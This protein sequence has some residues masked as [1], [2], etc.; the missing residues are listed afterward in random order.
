MEA[1]TAAARR[2][3]AGDLRPA[4]ARERRRTR[5]GTSRAPSTR[6]P[7]RSRAR[8]RCAAPWSP[9]WPTSCARRS[10]TCAARSRPSRTGCSRPDAATV[11]S[12]HEETLLLAR[13]VGDLQDLALAESGQLPLHSGAVSRSRTRCAPRWPRSG[14][15]PARGGS[16]SRRTFADGAWPWTPTASGWPR[17]CATCSRT[18]SP[19]RRTAARIRV[20]A[21]AR[22][23]GRVAV[24]VADSGAGI[25]AEH[26]P[27]VF[28][29]FY[30]AD[31]SR[32][33]TT[34]GAGLGLAIVKQLVE[35]HGGHGRRRP[36]SRARRPLHLH[37]AGF[38]GSSRLP[39]ISFSE[40]APARA[41]PPEDPMMTVTVLRSLPVR[42]A[43][44]RRRAQELPRPRRTTRDRGRPRPAPEAGRR[45]GEFSGAVLVARATASSIAAR[46]AAPPGRRARRTRRTRSSTSGRSTRPSRGWPSSSWRRKASSPSPTPWTSTFPSLPAE[47]RRRIT[48]AQLIEHRGGTGDVFGPQLRRL[49]PRAPARTPR[50]AP[51]VRRRPLEFEPGDAAAVLE[52]GVPPARARRSRKSPAARTTTR[53]RADLQARGHERHRRLSRRRR[54]RQ[55]CL[56]LHERRRRG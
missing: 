2:M 20:D 21:R 14:P 56:G 31:P 46:P 38:T 3:E 53:A 36:A 52:R 50:L 12:L 13:L 30:R 4:R 16:R 37:A 17:C 48:L 8:S 42:V 7:T 44:R 10:P 39:R 33:R 45:R 26:L 49:R 19:T 32:A 47:P 51:P 24:E 23:A 29:R 27:H 55:P 11:R 35:A 41:P 28:D 43:W 22:R 25:S 5:S 40:R 34:G 1:I 15:S 9:T 6:W 54:R 18:R